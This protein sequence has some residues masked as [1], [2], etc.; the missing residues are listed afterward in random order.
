MRSTP[1]CGPSACTSITSVIFRVCHRENPSPK[2]GVH[3]RYSGE[4]VRATDSHPTPTMAEVV[5]SA[6]GFPIVTLP[7]L[8]R[9]KLI[10]FRQ[11][12]QVH[13][14]DMLL[15]GLITPEIRAQVPADL[16]PR[17][18]EVERT[19]RDWH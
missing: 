10:A 4:K 5:Q 14:E 6:R 2:R 16:L 17:L 9:M 12:D 19:L 3:L 11:H 7:A 8:L 15:V 1:A 18:E 13:I